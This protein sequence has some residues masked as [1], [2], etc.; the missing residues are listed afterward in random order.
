MK[1]K[2]KTCPHKLYFAY[3]SNMN[4]EQMNVRCT[5]HELVCIGRLDGH[6]FRINSRGVATV[7][8]EKGAVVHG[9]VW[10]ISNKDEESLD[11]YEG[12]ANGLYHK[13]LV[14]V[15]LADGDK[16][17]ALVYVAADSS[18]GKFWGEYLNKIIKAAKLNKLPPKYIKELQGWTKLKRKY[19]QEEEEYITRLMA[20]RTHGLAR[21]RAEWYLN[22]AQSWTPEDYVEYTRFHLKTMDAPEEF[23]P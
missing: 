6:R 2:N 9:L 16:A 10:S 12:V 17:A 15:V 4:V 8:P 21:T 5:G 7:V 14:E 22:A 20:G 19:S 11:T 23:Y 13:E 18:E 1:T 3:G